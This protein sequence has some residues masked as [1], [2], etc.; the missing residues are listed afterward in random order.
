MLLQKKLNKELEPGVK[1]IQDLPIGSNEFMKFTGIK[2]LELVENSTFREDTNN[3]ELCIVILE[4]KVDIKDSKDIFNNLGNRGKIFEKKTTDSL[5]IGQKNSFEIHSLT[6]AKILLAYAKSTTKKKTKLIKASDNK[7]E[8]RGKYN[9]KR[10][11][12]NILDDES[13]ISENLLVVE[14]FTDMANWSSYPP[15]KHDQ[16]NLPE[17]S[18]LEE[19][20]Y[21]ELNPSQGFVFQRVYTLD[22]TIDETMAVENQDSVFVPRGFHPVGVPDG[23]DSYYLNVMAGPQ[24]IWKFNND[25]IHE[26]I[27]KRK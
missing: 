21:H 23:Y 10:L 12:N 1:I 22:K 19:I 18:L 26:W 15:H 8:H 9:N 7:V 27:I 6:K 13:T 4:G 5:Y 3:F 24:K 20:Y 25:K 2:V 11:V 14:V 17:E 16:D